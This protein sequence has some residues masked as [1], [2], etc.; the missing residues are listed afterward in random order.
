[1]PRVEIIFRE[2]KIRGSPRMKIFPRSHV[3]SLNNFEANSRLFAGH[4]EDLFSPVS[5]QCDAWK[6][7]EIYNRPRIYFSR[8]LTS[9]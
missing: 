8:D 5:S 6:N 2:R 3:D 9:K 7:I 4:T 1:M